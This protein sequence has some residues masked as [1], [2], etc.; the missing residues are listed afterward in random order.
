MYGD[1]HTVDLTHVFKRQNK[2]INGC[3]FLTTLLM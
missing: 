1:V 2:E 3:S